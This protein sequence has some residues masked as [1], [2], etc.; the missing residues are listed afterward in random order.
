MPLAK[1]L[2]R[3]SGDVAEEIVARLLVADLCEP[4]TVAPPGFI[5]LRL[6]ESWLAERLATAAVDPR[7]AVGRTRNHSGS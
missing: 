6:R 1:R 3:P 7:L 2:G 5:N 4:A